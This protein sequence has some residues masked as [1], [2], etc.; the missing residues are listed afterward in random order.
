LEEEIEVYRG[1]DELEKNKKAIER[2]LYANKLDDILVEMEGL[3]KQKRELMSEREVLLHKYEEFI[4]V[5]S[6]E[7][8]Q[9]TVLM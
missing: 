5:S 2:C 6:V 3:R 9:T 7:E 1:Y 8:D 4:K